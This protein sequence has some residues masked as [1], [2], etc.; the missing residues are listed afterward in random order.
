MGAEL[1]ERGIDSLADTTSNPPCIWE[2]RG[3]GSYRGRLVIFRYH[4]QLP[5]LLPSERG[6]WTTRRGILYPDPAGWRYEKSLSFP[7]APMG[8]LR[9]GWLDEDGGIGI[10][11]GAE[12][13]YETIGHSTIIALPYWFLASAGFALPMLWLMAAIRYGQRRR[14]GYCRSCGYDLRA[15][16]DRCPECGMPVTRKAEKS[17]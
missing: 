14:P 4:A 7:D 8:F 15:T 16:S 6:Q 13:E 2:E 9:F 10:R 12:R 17:S 1:A 5:S 11:F 3:L